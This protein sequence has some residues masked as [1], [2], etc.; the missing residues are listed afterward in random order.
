MR[1]TVSKETRSIL[2]QSRH[3]MG[4]DRFLCLER[5]PSRPRAHGSSPAPLGVVG[6]LALGGGGQG[7]S[8][9]ECEI[10][11]EQVGSGLWIGWRACWRRGPL[12][13]CL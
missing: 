3:D 6:H 9:S 8:G 7:D 10:P 12:V 11:P 1:K 5:V 13:S 2:R 4:I